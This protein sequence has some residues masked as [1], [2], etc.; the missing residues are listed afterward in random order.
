MA[1]N[2]A[3][4]TA[5]GSASTGEEAT[6]VL[7]DVVVVRSVSWSVNENPNVQ[8]WGDN[9][10][11]KYT[12][13]RVTRLSATGSVAGKLDCDKNINIHSHSASNQ[14]LSELSAELILWEANAGN[15]YWAFPCVVITSSTHEADMET[16][17]ITTW[18]FDFGSDGE[19]FRPGESGAPSKD[20]PTS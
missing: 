16:N 20:Y 2:A 1:N 8:E 14:K 4:D 11:G 7:N 19:Y 18:A 5:G 12:N 10:S 6:V 15:C 17:E 9:N 3:C 13:R